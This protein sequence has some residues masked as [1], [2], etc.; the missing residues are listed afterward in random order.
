VRDEWQEEHLTT[1]RAYALTALLRIQIAADHAAAASSARDLIAKIEA[2]RSRADMPDEE[3][4][5]H[6][7]LGVALMRVD[8]PAAAREHLERSVAMRE[9][10]DAPESLW[11]A[12]ARLYLAQ[13]LHRS[14]DQVGARRLLDLAAAAHRQH[15]V[16]GPQH[17]NLLTETRA[18]IAS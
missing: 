18:L 13:C 9:R 12:R 11:L 10:M 3:A 2:S 5:A 8:G 6:M 4:T 1:N 7:L 15:A 14:N 17:R 16:L